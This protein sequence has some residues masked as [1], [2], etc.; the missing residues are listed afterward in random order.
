MAILNDSRLSRVHANRMPTLQQ[1]KAP[2]GMRLRV[3]SALVTVMLVV[4]AVGY[5]VLAAPGA[6]RV[7]AVYPLL[8]LVGTLLFMVRRYTITTDAI[9]VQRWLWT[10]RLPLAGLQAVRFQP[11]VMSA[12]RRKFGNIGVFSF[13]GWY[14][15]K[16]LGLYRV[17]VTDLD[18]TVVLTYSDRCVVVSPD[19][20]E[21]FVRA[22]APAL[23]Q[24]SL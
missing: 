23:K 5:V 18:R 14:S 8:V 7:A 4:L 15:N 22:L 11:D 2:W 10:T 6:S 24:K 16:S 3:T 17:F 21:D 1:F 19:V 20:P 13:T 9:L 12:S